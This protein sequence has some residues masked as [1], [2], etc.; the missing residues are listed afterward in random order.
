MPAH[1]Y[2][3]QN[4]FRPVEGRADRLTK[5]V[6]RHFHRGDLVDYDQHD[7]RVGERCLYRGDGDPVDVGQ[8]YPIAPDADGRLEAGP[9]SSPVRPS[10]A[11]I[12]KPVR[13]PPVRISSVKKPPA[14]VL[15][16]SALR[17]TVVLPQPGLPVR[18]RCFLALDSLIM[19]RGRLFIWPVRDVLRRD[20]GSPEAGAVSGVE[21]EGHYVMPI[22]E[23]E[24]ARRA[25]CLVEVLDGIDADVAPHHHDRD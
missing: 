3:P 23:A 8:V 16:S 1:L 15:P 11:L 14:P 22:D 25:R 17:I 21:N 19:I 10:R 6:A 24:Q 5:N 2:S 12:E 20:P 4:V 9:A 18:R 7:S 13:F